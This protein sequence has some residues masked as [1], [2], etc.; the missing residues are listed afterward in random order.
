[1]DIREWVDELNKECQ[2]GREFRE[3]GSDVWTRELLPEEEE[4]LVAAA[5]VGE[6]SIYNRPLRKM[7]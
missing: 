6:L 2:Q 3:L 7:P 1:M 5:N 4:I